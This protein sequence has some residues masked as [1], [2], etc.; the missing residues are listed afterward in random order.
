MCGVVVVVVVGGV[1]GVGVGVYLVHSNRYVIGSVCMCGWD[2]V[3]LRG[4]SGVDVGVSEGW[5]SGEGR[6]EVGVIVGKG[7]CNGDEILFR[8]FSLREIDI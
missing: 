8:I 7:C 6:W 1:G 4:K 2:L 5:F 3:R